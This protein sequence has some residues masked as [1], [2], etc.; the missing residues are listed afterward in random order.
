MNMVFADSM[1]LH[2]TRFVWLPLNLLLVSMVSGTW[3]SDARAA[4]AVYP[5]KV[6]ANKR[7]LVDQKNAPFLVTGD[8]PQSLTVN[9][10]VAQ[11]DSYF[12]NRQA[13]GFNTMWINLLCDAYTGG[14][15]DGSAY[16]GMLPFAGYLPGGNNTAHYDLSKPNEA[17]FTRCDQMI[18]LAAKYNLLVFLD[19]IETGG[20]LTNMV[21]NGPNACNDYGKYLGNRYKKFDNIV[22]MSGNDFGT[23]SNPV[24]DA[25]VTAVARGIQA[26]D[27]RHIHTAELGGSFGLSTDDPNW[28]SIV[29]ISGAYTYFPTYAEVLNGYNRADTMPVFMVEACYDY[30]SLGQAHIAT[31]ATL[32]REEYWA[33]L[34]GATGLIYGNHYTW[35]FATGWQT[36][37]D[38]PGAAEIM[39]MKSFFESRPWYDLVP[40]QTHSTLTA[41]FGTFSSKGTIDAND[42]ATAARTPDGR[43]A[44]VYAPT[45]RS[46]TIDMTKL[47]GPVTARWFDPSNGA[48]MAIEGSPFSNN[49]ARSFTPPGDNHDGDGDWVLVLEA[50]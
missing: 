19:P 17:F 3:T 4:A 43:L 14:R 8:C 9:L 45:I 16:D 20:W 29:S 22:W 15:E 5:V 40:D 35:T 44:I 26:T 21:N 25:A 10:S 50:H 2:R 1:L 36:H 30:E 39:N 46:L 41:G 18:S 12:S 32:R 38:T 11:A 28:A 13:H 47:S 49:G 37:I 48:Y 31:P 7:Y 33:D 27:M 23:W 24:D 34:S 6:S 42:Y